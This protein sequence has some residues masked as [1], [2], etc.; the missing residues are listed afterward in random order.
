M[1]KTEW[2]YHLIILS[3]MF[4]FALVLTNTG[5]LAEPERDSWQKPLNYEPP[6]NG[7]PGDRGDGKNAGTRPFCPSTEKPFT[8][9]VPATNWGETY[10]EHP[11]FW[12]YIPYGTSSLELILRD[13]NTKDEIYRTEFPV[14]NGPG[15]MS[16]PLP[17]TAPPLKVETKYRWR[18]FLFCSDNKSDYFSVNGVI[19]RVELNSD[20]QNQLEAANNGRERVLIYAENGIWHET[21]TELVKLRLPHTQDPQVTADWNALLEHPWVRLENIADEP[22]VNVLYYKGNPWKMLGYAIANPTYKGNHE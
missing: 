7:A 5:L 1:T 21:L 20:V 12:L 17:S 3:L 13:E 19:K 18:F 10:G 22:L 14:T 16:F 2:P 9:L 11:T 8:A 4:A 6:N 15:I